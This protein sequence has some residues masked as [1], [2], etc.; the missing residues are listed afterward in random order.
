MARQDSSKKDE[1]DAF[2][3]QNIKQVFTDLSD[4]EMPSEIVDLLTMLKAQDKELDGKK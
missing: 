1:I 4:D 3:D 2:L